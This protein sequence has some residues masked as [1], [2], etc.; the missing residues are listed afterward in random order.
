MCVGQLGVSPACC[1]I[2]SCIDEYGHPFAQ[3]RC[4]T[5]EEEVETLVEEEEG[6]KVEEEA[7]TTFT[8]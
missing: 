1:H 5:L 8:V 4:T 7:P 6:D 3:E 2:T